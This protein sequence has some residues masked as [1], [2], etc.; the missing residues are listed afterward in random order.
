MRAL[1]LLCLFSLGGCVWSARV[2]GFSATGPESFLYTAETNTVITANDDG[3]AERLRR[4]WIADAV[5][6]HGMCGDGYVI[7]N[8]HFAP[9][10]VGPFANGG[11]ILYV[12]RC[13]LPPPPPPAVVT[14]GERG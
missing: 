13:L 9:A 7:E 1:L 3:V 14:R 5:Q 8:R 12:G 4:D 2:E 10:A 6:A 11:N